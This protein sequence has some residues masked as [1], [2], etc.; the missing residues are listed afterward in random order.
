MIVLIESRVIDK[1]VISGL[2]QSCEIQGNKGATC[3][4]K[5]VQVRGP[6]ISE[7]QA[8]AEIHS[9]YIK[10]SVLWYSAP[11]GPDTRQGAKGSDTKASS[12]PYSRVMK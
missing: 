11:L 10:T 4:N 12:L 5:E 1:K 2:D 9:S 7:H 3:K 6:G 8:G